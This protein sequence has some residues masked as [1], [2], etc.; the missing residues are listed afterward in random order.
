MRRSASGAGVR[1]CC[2]QLRPGRSGRSGC[3]TQAAF[4]TAG[5][6]GRFGRDERPV[7]LILGPCG[8]PALRASP[9]ARRSASCATSAAASPASASSA[10]MRSTSSLSSGLPGTMAP[11]S[12]AASRWSSRRSALRA[13]L[14]GPWQAKQFSA[15]IGRMSR[16]Y[17]SLPRPRRRAARRRAQL[18]GRE[19][20]DAYRCIEQLLDLSLRMPLRPCAICAFAD[21]LCFAGGRCSTAAAGIA[22]LQYLTPERMC[23]AMARAAALR[24]AGQQGLDDRQVLAGLLGQPAVVVAGLVVLPGDVAEGAEQ[25]SSA[26]PARWPGRRCRTSRRSGRAAGCRRRGPAR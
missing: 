25:E 26:G 6:S 19:Q 4:L 24:V 8:D 10:R 1:P 12:T 22:R 7:R 17:S 21:P 15:R 16:L 23:R 2:F 20:N 9:S 14:S 11:A 18:R 5:G 3:V 13:A